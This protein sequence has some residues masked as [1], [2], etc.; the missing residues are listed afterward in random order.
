MVLFYG[1]LRKKKVELVYVEILF[2]VCWR[3]VWIIDGNG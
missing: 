2:L 1:V 3:R